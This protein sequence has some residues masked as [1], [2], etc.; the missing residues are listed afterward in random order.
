MQNASSSLAVCDLAKSYGSVQAVDFVSFEIAPGEIFGLL[1]P[2]GAGKTTLLECT[3]GLREPDAGTIEIGGIDA[4]KNP[5]AVKAKIGAVLQSTALQ[6][7]MTPREALR[8]FGAFHARPV[9][10][11]RLIERFGLGEKADARFETLSG[12]QR[13]RLALALAFVNDPALLFL[14]EPTSGLDP[15]VRRELHGAI[16]QF[17]AEGRSVLLTTHYIEEA[18]ALCDRMAILHRGRIVA[19]G[20]PEELIARSPSHTRLIVRAARPLDCA[21]LAALPGIFSAVENGGAVTL[22]TRDTGPAIIELAR[23]LEAG[24]NELLD[25]QVKKTSLEDVFIELTGETCA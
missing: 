20:A 13:Q 25:L 14:D 11:E 19:S 3:V 1:G 17:R 15:Q 10:P 7:A 8:L 23:H 12:G 22:Q 16:R 21:A 2:N 6:D 4:R 24:G 5:G 18:H 9:A